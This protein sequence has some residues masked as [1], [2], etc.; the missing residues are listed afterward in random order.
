MRLAVHWY[1]DDAGR[2]L[3]ERPDDDV[4]AT[5]G[6]GAFE[7]VWRAELEIDEDAGSAL[8]VACDR[9]LKAEEWAA[10]HPVDD[11]DAQ[12]ADEFA[13]APSEPLLEGVDIG[14]KPGRCE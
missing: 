7:V 5:L 4:T 12:S 2:L 10:H 3:G 14:E 6:D 8:H 13:I 1:V 11:A 9:R